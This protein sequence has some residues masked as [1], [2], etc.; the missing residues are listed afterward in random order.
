MIRSHV[1]FGVER[2]KALRLPKE[3]IEIIAEHHGDSVISWFYEKAK[4]EDEAVRKEDFSYPGEPP[5]SKEAGIVMI[6]DTVEAAT[7]TLKKPTVPR[8][9]QQIRQLILDKVEAGQL[10]NCSLTIKDLESIRHA[11][12]R[13]LAGQFHSRIEYPKQKEN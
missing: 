9:E 12:T 8:L 5:K 1:K 13:I 3:V 7:R 6:A 4:A 11:F 2:A 10:D